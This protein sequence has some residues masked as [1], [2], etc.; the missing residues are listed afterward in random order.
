MVSDG[1]YKDNR[2]SAA[3]TTVPDKKIKGSL[4]IPGNRNDQNSYRAELGG[5]LASVVYTNKVSKNTISHP[6]RTQWYV[7][8]KEPWTCHLIISI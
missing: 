2:S 6:V 7:T 4:T 5:I 1:S 8:I 3:F